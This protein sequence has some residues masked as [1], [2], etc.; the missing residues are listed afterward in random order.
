M[1]R[2]T[3][4]VHASYIGPA[5][6]GL[7]NGDRCLIL[8]DEGS[9]MHVR[10]TT[11]ALKDTY[12]QVVPRDIVADHAAQQ[13]GDDNFGFEYGRSPRRVAINVEGVFAAGGTVALFEALEEQGHFE[14]LREAAREAVAMVRDRLATDEE[15]G[16]V[17]TALGQDADDVETSA[18]IAAIESVSSGVGQ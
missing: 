7:M 12:G 17:R 14:M 5:E 18:I 3:E 15:W 4:G 2:R 1:M 16:T 10:W 13:F 8:S 11:G 6:A 9:T